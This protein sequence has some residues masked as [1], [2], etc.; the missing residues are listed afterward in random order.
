MPYDQTTSQ[1]VEDDTMGT[2]VVKVSDTIVKITYL[3]NML[4]SFGNNF[5]T[6]LN[7]SISGVS[8]DSCYGESIEHNFTDVS[9][10]TRFYADNWYGCLLNKLGFDYSDLFIKFGMPDDIYDSS[11]T[12]NDGTFR[13]QKFAL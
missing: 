11:T 9:D 3:L 12:P 4:Y 10:M 1:Y 2:F 13:Y 6:G 8:F 7:Y 5:N